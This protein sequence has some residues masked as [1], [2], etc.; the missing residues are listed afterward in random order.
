M[1]E[2][3]TPEGARK[4][5]EDVLREAGLADE[6]EALRDGIDRGWLT[7]DCT[8]CA[9]LGAPSQRDGWTYCE[10]EGIPSSTGVRMGLVAGYPF[11]ASSYG[12]QFREARPVCRLYQRRE[13]TDA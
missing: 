4:I 13:G 2:R 5:A 7:A 9:H 3:L 1:P 12:E 10:M 6:A 11:E 8:T